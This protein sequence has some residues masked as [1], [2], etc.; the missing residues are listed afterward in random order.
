MTTVTQTPPER[1]PVCG[2]EEEGRNTDE[3]RVTNVFYMCGAM[4]VSYSHGATEWLQPC[5]HAM[6]A[7][8]RVGATLQP[9]PLEQARQ[10][11]VDAA[12]RFDAEYQKFSS[13]IYAE[14]WPDAA[15]AEFHSTAR[16]Y[17]AL[18]EPTP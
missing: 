11:L 15:E 12:L 4:W 13:S 14:D 6:T 7:A 5:V 17:L 2:W 9:T 8:L 1:C 16:A 10:A 18:L 3:G